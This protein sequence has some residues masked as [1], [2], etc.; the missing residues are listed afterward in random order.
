MGGMVVVLVLLSHPD[1]AR[2]RSR[3]G[4]KLIDSDPDAVQSVRRS[5]SA[6]AAGAPAVH[7]CRTCCN[8]Y[9]PSCLCI[10]SCAEVSAV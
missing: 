6:A 5:P 8:G 10:A 3:V 4:A 7:A 2:A 9:I 1:L